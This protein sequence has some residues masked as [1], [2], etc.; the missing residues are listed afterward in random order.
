[1][2]DIRYAGFL[3]V[4]PFLRELVLAENP[5]AAK[6]GYRAAIREMLPGLPTL[7]G[8]ALG[9]YQQDGED[10]HTGS[11]DLSHLLRTASNTTNKIYIIIN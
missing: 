7:D 2:H 8:V 4:C 3:T 6:P 5:C 1:M 10:G 11:G 9:N